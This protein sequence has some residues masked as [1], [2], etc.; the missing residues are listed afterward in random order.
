MGY[1]YAV[2]IKAIWLR[3]VGSSQPVA[4]HRVTGSRLTKRLLM[5]ERKPKRR[6]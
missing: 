6:N 2:A 3:S 5:K 1:I 4:P